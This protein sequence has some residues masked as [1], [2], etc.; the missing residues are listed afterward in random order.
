MEDREELDS[1]YNALKEKY[2]LPEFTSLCE[3]FDIEKAF[4]KDS[5]YILREIRRA[6]HEKFSAYL[7]LLETLT[8]PTAP[9]MFIFSIIRGLG[10]EEKKNIKEIYKKLSKLQ[11]SVM[12]L[13]TIYD[14]AKEAEYIIESFNEWQN[15]KKDLMDIVEKLEKGLEQDS[16]MKK[17]A[18]FG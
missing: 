8:N 1:Q 10:E 5:S 7:H 4:E 16:D 11:L 14:E 13:D 18:Y 2:S 12:K 15:A 6:I 3:D 9:P 17:S